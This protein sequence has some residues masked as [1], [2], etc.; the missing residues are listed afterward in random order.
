MNSKLEQR[1]EMA[2]Q[3]QE[4]LMDRDRQICELFDK[5]EKF[6][7]KLRYGRTSLRPTDKD[8]VHSG[9]LLK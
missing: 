8:V 1:I 6:A 4:V 9:M 2:K 7:K 5:A 3:D